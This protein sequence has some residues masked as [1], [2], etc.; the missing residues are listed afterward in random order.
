VQTYWAIVMEEE[1]FP[2]KTTFLATVWLL[3]EDH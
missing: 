1:R 2:P 3:A